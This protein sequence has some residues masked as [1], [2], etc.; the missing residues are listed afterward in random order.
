M[1][2]M[3]S[4][5]ARE[6]GEVA[7]PASDTVLPARR[8]LALCDRA[9]ARLDASERTCLAVL[10]AAMA[11]SAAASLWLTRGTVFFS[12]EFTYFVANRGFDFKA[13]LSPHNGHLIA[14]VR[15]IYAAVFEVFGADYLVFRLLEVLGIALVAGLVF[16]YAK[17][18]IG[19]AAALAPSV[20]LLFLGSSPDVTL[21]PLGI[22]HVYSVA[23]GLGALL[24]LERG[25]ARGDLASC[26]LLFV[27]V[28]TFSI[29]LAFLA[30]VTVS[31]LLRA[32]RWRRA[33]IFLIPSAMCG[34]WLLTPKLTGPL[35]GA[36]TGFRISNVPL[37]PNFVAD[38]AAAVAAVLTGLSH[39]FSNAAIGNP[40]SAPD[41][42][43]APWGYLIAAVATAALVFRLRRGGVPASL[44]SSLTVLLVFWS[45]AALVAEL[46]RYPYSQRYIYAA[47][48]TT[49]LVA[50]DALAGIRISRRALLALLAG[51][52]LALGANLSQLR[53]AAGLL[54]S[55]SAS[56]RAVLTSLEV[57]RHRVA[58]GF[59]PFA[60]PPRVTFA[61]IVVG[62]AGPT[63]AAAHRNGSFAFSLAELR[64]Q[65]E[66]VR[67]LADSTLAAALRIGLGPEPAP[68]SGHRC[69]QHD[70]SRGTSKELTLRSPGILLRSAAPASVTMRRFATRRTVNVGRLSPG[71]LVA[72]QI[73]PDSAPEPW[74]VALSATG[75]PTTVCDLAVS[76]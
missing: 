60:A 48:V 68:R 54:R 2:G 24:A 15:L 71:R 69:L 50:S 67:E 22:T 12:D 27:S 23:A 66:P 19:P 73:P 74:R 47:A 36:N 70:G 33:W 4:L 46:N 34:I 10:G 53:A 29:G 7:T 38:A 58:P 9:I 45:S 64:A 26:V 14:G 75:R 62:G 32:D 31:V 3:P 8:L 11:L 40:G 57:A 1:A 63:L 39:D 30:G 16:V 55:D 13:L 44:W 76:R 37:V 28:A 6:S 52:V 20:L 51:S 43:S 41:I 42:T 21:S 61:Y 65:P 17:R 72:L 25:N 35:Y 18:R 49:L 5:D 59:V 56:S